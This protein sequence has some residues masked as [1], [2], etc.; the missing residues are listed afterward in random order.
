MI[1]EAQSTIQIVDNSR[2][3]NSRLDDFFPLTTL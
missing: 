1:S 2:S 3:G